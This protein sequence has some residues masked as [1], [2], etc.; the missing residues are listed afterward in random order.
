MPNEEMILSLHRQQWPVASEE[1]A[2]RLGDAGVALFKFAL[3]SSR[4]CPN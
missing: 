4:F 3:D 1:R 2:N